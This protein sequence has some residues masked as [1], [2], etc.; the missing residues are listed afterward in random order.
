M[1]G[2]AASNANSVVSG[3][4]GRG[5]G[6]PTFQTALQIGGR[7]WPSSP[8]AP[9]YHA[10]T[11]HRARAPR[12]GLD[13]HRGIRAATARARL[14]QDGGISSQLDPQRHRRNTEARTGEWVCGRCDGGCRRPYREEPGA[15]QR[16]RLP[17][18]DRSEEHTSELQSRL[19]LVCRLLLEKKNTDTE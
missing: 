18:Y 19:H 9:G 11:H 13:L 8:I 4:Y 10:P 12:L 1:Q 7:Q 5:E 3:Q 15:I 16:G 14:L 17:E 2:V 6:V